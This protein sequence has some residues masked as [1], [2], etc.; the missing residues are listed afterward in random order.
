MWF[1]K[2]ES[3]DKEAIILWKRFRSLCIKEFDKIYSILNIKFDIISGESLY[4]KKMGKTI[5][6]LESKNLIS[7]SD[8]EKVLAREIAK[9]ARQVQECANI[10]LD[11]N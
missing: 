5:K 1:N 4:N 8:R 7:D 11:K 10:P 6:E 3:G 2:L 9:Y